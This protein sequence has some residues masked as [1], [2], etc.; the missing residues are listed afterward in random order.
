MSAPIDIG[1]AWVH[2]RTRPDPLGVTHEGDGANFAL[3]SRH[4][5]RVDLC[6]FDTTGTRERRLTLPERTGDVWHGFLAGVAPGQ[7]Y[8]YRVHGP[9]APEQGHR[10]NA[11]KLLVD[12]YAR[13]LSGRLVNHDANFGF[14][15]HAPEADLDFDTRDN[16]AFM[17]RCIVVTD[18]PDEGAGHRPRIPWR[19]SIL[20]ELH[21][22]GMTRR[23][24]D[25]A[26][27]L[28]GTF[29]GL[30][31]EAV[32]GHL[33]ALGVTAIEL[34]PIF[35]F[36][37]EPHLVA[38]GLTNY[39]GYNP[40]CFL[41]PDP[42][43]A[44]GEARAELREMVRRYHEAGIEV[45]LD[46]V[47]NHTGEGW[48]LGPTLSLRG[49][50][51]QSY[52]RLVPGAPRYY[53]DDTGCG[54]TLD[55][56]REPGIG[57]VIGSLRHW[58]GEMGIDGFRFD[59]ATTLARTDA[60]FDPD[61]PLIRAIRSDPVLAGVKLIAEPWDVGPGGYRLGGFRQR[62]AEWNDRYRN[63]VR[64]FWRGDGGV[65]GEL[66]RRLTGSADLF[67][68]H[69][70]GPAASLDYVTSHDGFTLADL[71]SYEK[72]HNEANGEGNRD[73]SD[74]NISASYGVE[75][76]TDDP[77]VNATRARQM[78]N[79]LAT[80]LLSQG[81]PMLLAG[82]EMGRTQSGNNNS[83]CQDNAT[84]WIDWSQLAT[85][86]GHAQAEF[87][88]R[89]IALRERHP[90]LRRER[91]LTGRPSAGGTLADASWWSP[92]GREM[93]P[94][95]WELPY[96]RVLGLLIAGADEDGAQ[97]ETGHLLVLLNAHDGSVPFRLPVTLG[98]AA[99]T[100]LLDTTK[101]AT[102]GHAAGEIVPI[103]PRSLVVLE[104]VTK[105][106]VRAAPPVTPARRDVAVTADT[107]ARLSAAAGIEA[108][109]WSLAGREELASRETRLALLAAMGL[110]VTSERHACE[111]AETLE[112]AR[113]RTMLPPAC[114]LRIGRPAPAPGIEMTIP[115]RDLGRPLAW[116]IALEDGGSVGGEVIAGT[117]AA[118]ASRH[119]D[120]R[121]MMRLV[122]PLPADLPLGYHRLEM[123]LAGA[124]SHGTLIVAP[125][126]AYLPQWL[127]GGRRQW[128]LAAQIYSLRRLSP[129]AIDWG[130][131][132][133]GMLGEIAPL[134]GREGGALIGINPLHA[135]FR[136]EPRR[137]SPYSP[138]SRLF[139][140]A[141][142]IDIGAVPELAECAAAREL[143]AANAALAPGA[144]CDLVDHPA[145]SR[146][147][148]V[149]LDAL[150]RCFESRH[151]PGSPSSRRRA[152][153]A[154]RAERGE[155]LARFAL[156]E[157]LEERLGPP[158]TWPAA[159]ANP[160]APEVQA[161]ARDSADRCAFFAY[162]QFEADRQLAA[163]AATCRGS[164]VAGGLYGDLAV[165]A[166]PDG[167]EI[168]ADPGTF[169]RTARFGAPPDPFS[170]T[171]Q[172][173]GMPPVSPHALS[174]DA[175][176][177]LAALL[178]ANMRH[179]A[180]LRLDH[181]MWLERMFWIPS[182]G[183]ARDGTYVRFPRDDLM[184][185]LALESHRN[186]CLVVG[187]DLGT[188]PDGFRDRMRE[189]AILSYRFMRF[190][191]HPDGLFHRPQSY[192]ALA[193]ATPA[194]HDLATIRGFW[195]GRDIE[196]KRAA[197]LVTD[198]AATA[199]TA[200]RAIERAQLIAALADQH[201]LPPDFPVHLA[202]G[203]DAMAALVEAVHRFLARTP[204][205]LAML[206]LEDLAGV[207][208]QTN[209][210][211][212]IDSY[213]NW[214]RRLPAD[215]TAQRL[216]ERLQRAARAMQMEGR[217]Q[218]P[219]DANGGAT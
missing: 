131:G 158:H 10:F 117:L 203:D 200:T 15:R 163:V 140:D 45:I 67:H 33:R 132:D 145:V 215:L 95:D 58:A 113:W 179:A 68:G 2:D 18:A 89:L 34:M 112:L 206:N 62:F 14:P 44:A 139:L 137:A 209:L 9:Y 164:G 12:P 90:A 123:A 103:A 134:V 101:A 168:W 194:S 184:G 197:G 83:Y 70:L 86:E 19:R 219:A 26:E 63:A 195:L 59:L 97:S 205:A 107:L 170:E 110:D 185:V 178:R 20:Y 193:L 213:P 29:A 217:A 149:A 84:S 135:L 75:G 207:V 52:Y 147:K 60:G 69:T 7:L 120:G 160:A 71:V 204:S 1:P 31:S 105:D 5:E 42:R 181:V 98:I 154:F 91:F 151:P 143:I 13:A 72:K 64:A 22:A 99:W 114:V 126:H 167:A 36:A 23:H 174:A 141:L 56:S 218:A 49:I 77:V 125:A 127:S 4:A 191:R 146:S 162:L 76:P 129:G 116:R 25:V 80:L 187:E 196:A 85:P 183:T 94:A 192:P 53:V 211:G 159:Y 37:D 111:S 155:A 73:G 40:Y 8:G 35:P 115:A 87:V 47:Y 27:G 166:A 201:L 136:S 142:T 28:R 61:A 16:A 50:D 208:D 148:L 106:A 190:E 78:R 79:M 212:T 30:A 165:G 74:D 182:G 100:T 109:Y 82:D 150:H 39:W 11:N 173:W 102:T 6:L 171:G 41:A 176:R 188:V 175:Y 153:D 108:S 46:V 133:L 199:A 92:E 177:P 3:F 104:S 32:I 88:R 214:R 210:P 17:P 189:E 51:N 24:P 198:A 55:L 144:P 81:V 66:A 93:T 54:N 169:A 138:S 216:A 157:A 21:V 57:L 43:Y 96:A 202:I 119:V 130:I 38:K 152:F 118:V 156:F 124:V 48:H 161:F 172:D 65:I 122:L 121:H 186:R 180:A 128:G